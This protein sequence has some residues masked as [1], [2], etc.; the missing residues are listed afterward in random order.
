[1]GWL[2]LD[3]SAAIGLDSG[4][5]D[6][7]ADLTAGLRASEDLM[8]ML[9]LFNEGRTG[10]PVETR[11][12]PSLAFAVAEDTHVQLGVT[13]GLRGDRRTGVSLS[14]WSRF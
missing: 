2:T 14:L 8:F 3:L 12:A 13:T 1:G 10:E 6:I 7:K 11:L 5:S 9:Q 4:D